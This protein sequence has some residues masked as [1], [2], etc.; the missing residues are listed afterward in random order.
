[1]GVHGRDHA[2][3]GFSVIAGNEIFSAMLGIPEFEIGHMDVH[4]P[5]HPLNAF[6]AIVG[7]GV[8]NK[9]QTQAAFYCDNQRFQNLRH[10]VL[11]RDEV[12]VVTTD[13]LQI[14]H[15]LRK[16]TRRD[17][18]AFTELAGL[19]ILAK[20]TAQIAPAEKDCARYVPP[21]QTIFLAEMRERGGDARKPAT[22]ADAD[23][24]VVTVDLAI[25]RADAA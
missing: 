16:L 24:V 6:E 1:M 18:G 7:G 23:L 10:H 2:A 9:R 21:A 20:N 5:I 22:L 4:Y 3:C 19:K 25:A 8:I 17:F 14:E 12:D 11:R 15:H 13:P